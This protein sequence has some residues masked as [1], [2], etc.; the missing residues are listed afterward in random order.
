MI[1]SRL[2]LVIAA[3]A[4]VASACVTHIAP[5]KPKHRHFDAGEY[6]GGTRAHGGSLYAGDRGMFEDDIAGRVGDIVVINIDER[7]VASRDATTKLTQSDK[8][9]YGLPA[10]VG[11]LAALQ[12]KYPDLDPKQLFA[13][14]KDVQFAGGGQ[15]ARSGKL[16]ATLPVRVAQV[17]PNGDLY[18]EGT[19]VV[20]VGTE[21]H[22]LYISGI[23]RHQD[24]AEDDT[25]PSSR[26]A[27][28]EIEYTGRGDVS[29]QQR[30][31][32]LSR[33]LAKAWP[34]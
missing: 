11:L 29:D 20:M 21:E 2:A 4:L 10:A 30:R 25:V 12:G 9:S 19:K 17:L 3:I 23:V 33:I 5:Y 26:L 13:S 22:H 15:I 6:G 18:V 32:W 14:N 27:E 7:E 31:G 28:A 1:A 34:F 8:A 16:V 24:L